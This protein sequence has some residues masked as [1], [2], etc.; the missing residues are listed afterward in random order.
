MTQALEMKKEAQANYKRH[1]EALRLQ[2]AAKTG[3]T[4]TRKDKRDAILY[5]KSHKA[6]WKSKME[7]MVSK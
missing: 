2:Y 1:S 4:F 3:P 7:E 6:Y 5:H